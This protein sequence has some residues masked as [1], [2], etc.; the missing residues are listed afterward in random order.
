[1]NWIGVNN[2]MTKYKYIIHTKSGQHHATEPQTDLSRLLVEAKR[3]IAL[4]CETDDEINQQNK[5]V[6]PVIDG[7]RDHLKEIDVQAKLAGKKSP[8]KQPRGKRGPARKP[9]PDFLPPYEEL[10]LDP[11]IPPSKQYAYVKWWRQKK[12]LEALQAEQAR[13][14][15]K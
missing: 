1:M 5:L 7:I 6:K 8:D 4:V 2:Q 11:N 3:L 15:I 9:L 10:D 14:Q 13:K 12:R